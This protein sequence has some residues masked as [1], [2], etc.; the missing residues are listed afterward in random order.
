MVTKAKAKAKAF[1]FTQ[2]VDRVEDRGERLS[3]PP[4]AAPLADSSL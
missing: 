2:L 3:L 1:A 4:N